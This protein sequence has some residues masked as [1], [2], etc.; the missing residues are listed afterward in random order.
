M[1]VHGFPIGYSNRSISVNVS[2]P[3]QPY[4]SETH[5]QILYSSQPA[6]FAVYYCTAPFVCKELSAEGEIK[7]KYLVEENCPHLFPR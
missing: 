7:E 2:L 3:F 1:F 4:C 5:Q 6:N